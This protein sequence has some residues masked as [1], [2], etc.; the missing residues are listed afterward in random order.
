MTF[1]KS[2]LLKKNHPENSFYIPYAKIISLKASSP[3]GARLRKSPPLTESTQVHNTN[4]CSDLYGLTALLATLL[5]T[6]L[7]TCRLQFLRS[8]ARG[9]M[10]TVEVFELRA[11]VVVHIQKVKGKL[12]KRTANYSNRAI[13]G[14]IRKRTRN[15]R[16]KQQIIQTG[17]LANKV[18]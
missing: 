2:P 11:A 10:T 6:S 8:S 3:K 7:L 12:E 4:A 18:G 15:W 14:H 5:L 16:K 17:G 1:P 9:R 13:R